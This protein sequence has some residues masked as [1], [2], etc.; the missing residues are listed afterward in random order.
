MLE[1]LDRFTGTDCYHQWSILFPQIVLTDGTKYVAEEAG[2]YW[3]MDAVASHQP[4][5]LRH[6]D[7]RLQEV[8]FWTLKVNQEKRS[9]VLSCVADSDCKPAVV[10]RI[11]YTDFPLPE[12]K[13]YVAVG[14]PTVI[15]LPSEY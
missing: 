15:M 4:K 14:D 2:A 11:E 3:L 1:D 10:Q 9:A 6:Q 13:L 12:I 5:L 7:R 8:Q